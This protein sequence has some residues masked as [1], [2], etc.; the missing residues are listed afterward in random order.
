MHWWIAEPLVSVLFQR[1][2]FTAADSQATALA[3]AIYGLG[4]PAFVMQKILQPLYFAREDTR[5]PFRYAVV[6]MFVNA[7]LAIGL[8]PFVGFLAAAIGTTAASWA[9]VYLLWR[10]R[11][12]MGAAAEFEAA[13]VIRA[14]R[15]LIASLAMGFCLLAANW[16]LADALHDARWRY[17]ALVGLIATG[18]I[19][20]F[21]I[22][23]AIGAVSMAE[24]RRLTPDT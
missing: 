24:L 6:S 5:S 22:G 8:A 20:Y 23:E 7:A 11:R 4:L 1:G 18:A 15:I 16:L 2:S 13:F 3:L 21:A 9:M 10:G 17:L 19:S 12:N 14:R